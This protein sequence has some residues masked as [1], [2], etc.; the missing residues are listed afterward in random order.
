MKTTKKIEVEKTFYLSPL[1]AFGL[2]FGAALFIFLFIMKM[3][4]KKPDLVINSDTITPLTSILIMKKQDKNFLFVDLRS[5][6]EFELEHI[7]GAVNLP[8]YQGK[9]LKEFSILDAKAILK[10]AGKTVSPNRNKKWILY[11]LSSGDPFVD[12][13]QEVL[14]KKGIKVYRLTVGW[15]DWRNSFNSWIPEP[16]TPNFNISIFT[17]GKRILV[18]PPLPLPEI[19][20]P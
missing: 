11:S 1:L 2:S 7:K 18:P 20:S 10:N 8:S 5:S 17:E 12:E 14:R 19:I 9:T 4:S 15:N 3:A 16:L 13:F 6:Q